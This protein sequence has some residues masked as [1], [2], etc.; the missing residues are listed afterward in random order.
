[1]SDWSI[2]SSKK[3]N[4]SDVSGRT[5]EC[6][7]LTKM[8]WCVASDG[9]IDKSI[10]ETAYEY[11]CGAW[12]QECEYIFSKVEKTVEKSG[13]MCR[14]CQTDV[15]VYTCASG[16]ADAGKT[17]NKTSCGQWAQCVADNATSPGENGGIIASGSTSDS[18]LQNMTYIIGVILV[19]A[20]AFVLYG[21]FKGTKEE[22]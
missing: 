19:I 21:A 12:S 8:R 20:I 17:Q 2:E 14:N 15:Y 3:E 13:T 9:K 5:R 6:K 16:K 18:I 10:Y 7:N 22:S 1:L 11:E 4:Q